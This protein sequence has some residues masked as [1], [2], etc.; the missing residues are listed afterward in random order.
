MK[1]RPD[2]KAPLKDGSGIKS[3]IL[4]YFLYAS[5]LILSAAAIAATLTPSAPDNATTETVA[6]IAPAAATPLDATLL[7]WD[8]LRQSDAFGFGD[9]ASFLIAH[10][11]WPGEARMRRLAES[12]ADLIAVNASLIVNFFT[13]YPPTSASGKG[14]YAEALSATGRSTEAMQMARAAWTGGNLPP[15]LEARLVA[16]FGSI[17]TAT[18]QDQRMERLL[19]D[20]STTAASRQILAVSAVRQP[21]YAARL[22]M[23][24][25]SPEA[26]DSFSNGSNDPGFLVDRARWLND[27]GRWSEAREVLSRPMQLSAAPL[28]ARKWLAVLLDFARTASKDNQSSIA[29]SI[30]LNAEKAFPAGT[31][32]RDT[33][34]ET[35]DVYTSLVWLGGQVALRQLGRPADAI[36]L[37]DRYARAAKTPQTQTKG[38]YWAGRAAIYAGDNARAASYFTAAAQHGDQFYGQ[39]AAER[40]GRPTG[41]I[42]QPLPIEIT[43]AARASF[44]ASELVQAA[45]LL[46]VRGRWQDQTLFLRTIAQNV[47]TDADHVL[48]AELA[49]AIRRPDLGVMVSRNW[50]NSGGGDPI[51][52]GFPEV[53]VPAMQQRQWTM[54]HAIS[55]QES[56]FDRQIISPAGA[57][58]LMQLMPGTARE[59]AGKIGMTYDF[60]R[61]TDDPIYN[62]M[63]GSSFFAN[64]LDYYGGNYVL[65][66][67]AYNAGPGNVRKWLAANGDPRIP[68]VDVIDWIEAIPIS[69]TRGYVQRVL[70]NAVVYDTLNPATALI[71]KQNRLSA[72]L[73]KNNPG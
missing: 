65:A 58:G 24:L 3:S 39:L 59:T 52:V 62:I 20:R 47:E 70:E 9:Y 14:R 38:W 71:P 21:L 28:D 32:V 37:F 5:P 6:P 40:V 26:Q 29:L 69:E 11:G 18:D 36:T 43:P 35:R 73:G 49:T 64:L 48:A 42:P 23:Q 61:L 22:A 13:R 25:K 12:K 51:R 7:N 56:Q 15:D 10:P 33:D 17:F 57:R 72:Y 68:G 60:N 55:R 34:L 63:L 46:G 54:I 16:R 19:A 2:C 53:A 4:R 41:I 45:K 50:R 67:A 66:V 8:R 1:Q 30:A 31:N 27:L 44:Q